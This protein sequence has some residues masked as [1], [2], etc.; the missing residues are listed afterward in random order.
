M[1]Q[2]ERRDFTLDKVEVETRDDSEGM[3]LVGHAAVFDSES[4]D[5]G[6][7][8]EVIRRG[9]FQK[10]LDEN[11]IRAFHNHN[12]DMVIGRTRAG[13]L[14]LSEDNEGLRAEI[15]LPDTS[16]ARD[17]MISVQR[18]DITGMSFGFMVRQGG[19]NIFERE[20]GSLLRELTDIDLIEVSSTPIPAY[21][22]TDIAQRSIDAF[23]ASQKIS[24]TGFK[25][26]QQK[27]KMLERF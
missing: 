25:R 10:S 18:G 1:D 26:I 13:T 17:L 20:D 24:E 22:A 19:Q 3:R 2:M 11:D 5:L 27:R 23:R 8:R 4:L 21:P 9:A 6:G 7:F 14:R 16:F 15:D 12:S